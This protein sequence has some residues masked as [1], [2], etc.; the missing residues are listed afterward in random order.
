MEQSFS[1][2]LG[3]AGAAVLGGA[4]GIQRMAAAKPAGFRTHL[5][6]A[7]ASAAFTAMG[8]HLHDTRIPSYVVVGIGFL[9]AGAIVRQGS[10]PHG[11]TT[12]ASIWM[13]AAIGLAM[14]YAT[15]FG[16]QVALVATLLTLTALILSDTEIIR[17]FRIPRKATMRITC[18]SPEI[19][20]GQI[21]QAFRDAQVRFE[22]SDIVSI[23]IEG[24]NQIVELEYLI[25][26]PSK[27]DISGL[28]REI[29]A[30]SGVRRV[31]ANEPF[32]VG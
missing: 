28:T 29:G 15:S 14:G 23:Q 2:L 5:I 27:R 31:E 30:L 12:A 25:Q 8:A 18:V 3:I 1:P 6:V 11:L 21:T 19:S 32:F 7:A 9:G 10:T 4:I 20:M 22:S 24:E 26:M 17:M 13:V 16:V